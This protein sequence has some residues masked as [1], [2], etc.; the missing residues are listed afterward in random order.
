LNDTLRRLGKEFRVAVLNGLLCGAVIF[1]V[2]SLGWKNPRIGLLI[3]AS[4]MIVIMSASIVG[5]TVPLALKR[6]NV[7]P[8]IAIGPFITISNDILGLLIYMWIAMMFLQY[9]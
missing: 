8:A 4:L 1:L 6:F 5:G 9:L 3:G 2:V 7:D